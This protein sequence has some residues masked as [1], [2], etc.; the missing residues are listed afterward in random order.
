VLEQADRYQLVLSTVKQLRVLDALDADPRLGDYYDLAVAVPNNVVTT[1]FMSQ[2]FYVFLCHN[3]F[4][5]F[6]DKNFFFSQNY[7]LCHKNIFFVTKLFFLK[8]NILFC[9]K[10]NCFSNFFYDLY[11]KQKIYSENFF[12]SSNP[13]LLFKGSFAD[14]HCVFFFFFQSLLVSPVAGFGPA[15]LF[16][17]ASATSASSDVAIALTTS[18]PPPSAIFL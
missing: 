18:F 16:Q 14:C 12:G 7:F 9:H 2:I 13:F 11:F 6:S 1:F 17:L 4:M 15:C 10:Y 5:S 8:Q 3:F